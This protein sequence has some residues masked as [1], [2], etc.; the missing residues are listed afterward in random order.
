MNTNIDRVIK[1]LETLATFNET[2]GN[3]VTRHCFTKED[4][5]A[6]EYIKNEL[7][8]LDVKI[9]EDGYSNLFGRLDGRN[10][11]APAIIIGSH[12]DS[13]TNGG[14]FDGPAGLVSA[15]ETIRV[16]KEKGIEHTYPIEFVAM[17]DEEG[18]RF[19]TGLSN[20]RALTGV[21]KEEELDNV[22]DKNGITLRQAMIDFGIT[23]DLENARRD[24]DS[25]K[26]FIELH[27]EQGPILEEEKKDVGLVEVIVGLNRYDVSFRGKAGHAGTTPMD[28][29]RDAMVAAAEFVLAVNSAAKEIGGGTVGTVGQMSLSPNASNVIPGLVTLAVDTRSTSEERLA[30]LAE[31]L[32]ESI[33]S[34]K[35]KYN[36]EVESVRNLYVS[37][38][39]MSEEN[40]QI[41]EKVCKDLGFDSIRMNSGAGHDAMI[42]AGIAP[43]SLIFVPSKNGLSHHPDEWTDYNQLHKGIE[44]M[45]HTVIELSK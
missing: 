14:P 7:S 35:D 4:R 45:L 16:I 37:P 11:D 26:S 38:V 8:K 5:Q 36:V 23:P 21:M 41:M 18:V 24:E 17:N 13:V 32:D 10:P 3:G 25:I 9:W 39:K 42:M 12:F 31:K 19:G 2:P 6:R 1:D 30:A 33:D 44:L 22:K 20:S 29:R 34:I 28:R 43:S 27:I 40:L 15:L